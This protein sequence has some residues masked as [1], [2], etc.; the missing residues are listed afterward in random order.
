MPSFL[1]PLHEFNQCHSPGGTSEGG[2][3]C[4]QTTSSPAHTRPIP[5]ARLQASANAYTAAHG[6]GPVV[7]PY[8]TVNQIR[9]GH[10]ADAYDA[11]PL[12]DSKNPAVIAAYGALAREVRAQWDHAVAGGM[13]FEPWTKPG[14]PYDTSVE[15]ADDVRANRHMYFYPGGSPNALM[16]KVDPQTGVSTNEMFRAVHDLYGHAAGGYGF[17]PRGEE[18]AWIA[19]SQ[20]F[21]KAARPALTVETRGQN[22]FVN[23]GKQNYNPDG[24]YK[25]IPAEDRPYAVQKLALLPAEFV[26]LPKD[27]SRGVSE[28]AQNEVS[29]RLCVSSGSDS[30]VYAMGEGQ[31]AKVPSAFSEVQ[32]QTSRRAVQPDYRRYSGP[33]TMPSSIYTTSLGDGCSDRAQSKYRPNNPIPRLREG[34]R[35]GSFVEG[36][37]SKAGRNHR[38]DNA[39]LEMDA[40]KDAVKTP[41]FVRKPAPVKPEDE[42]RYPRPPKR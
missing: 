31:P 39:R 38:G 33:R 4:S 6:L 29:H 26:E 1:T 28:T 36:Q 11:L 12:D 18:N 8:V 7:H 24:S 37:Q 21:S 16:S 19:H 20:M 41:P 30:S 34:K 42:L 10:I 27:I 40:T 25:N 3:F 2:E 22:S 32:S 17:G 13:T 14:Q 35:A 9:A 5:N 23:F 15:M